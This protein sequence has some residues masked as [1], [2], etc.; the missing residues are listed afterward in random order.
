MTEPLDG[1]AHGVDS[2]EGAFELPCL[3]KMIEK[4]GN[5]GDLVGFFGH[6]ELRQRETG[7][8]RVSAERVRRLQ[9][10]A[11]GVRAARG[12]A[13]NGDEVVPLGPKRLDP[14]LETAPEGQGIDAI[15]HR[16]RSIATAR[17]QRARPALAGN[18]VM[19][20]REFSQKIQRM[21]APSGG[22]VEIVI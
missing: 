21:F 10:F 9:P 15:D 5:G 19:E 7:V 13:V 8:C 4:L 6:S 20:R 3:C 17:S 1:S 2:H 11:F 16:W 12:L 22:L 14:A 18:A